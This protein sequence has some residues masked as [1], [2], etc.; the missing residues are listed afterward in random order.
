MFKILS[1]FHHTNSN[2]K[3]NV[4]TKTLL[5]VAKGKFSIEKVW[6]QSK[7]IIWLFFNFS[8]LDSSTVILVYV[9]IYLHNQSI[10]STLI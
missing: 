6:A 7:G 1:L 3:L 5:T 2:S 10:K 8:L 9:M 4:D